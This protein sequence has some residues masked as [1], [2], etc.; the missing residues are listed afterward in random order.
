[1]KFD[2][3]EGKWK[4]LHG[5]GINKKGNIVIYSNDNHIANII[6]NKNDSANARL[7]ASAPELL[8]AL[9][10]ANI[11]LSKL[12]TMYY[13]ETNSMPYI[14]ELPEIENLIEKASGK[15]WKEIINEQ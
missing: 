13:E 5:D 8:K 14:K 4:G 3:T 7:I 6:K 1:M 12:Y 10:N 11:A 15:S 9:I 2:Y